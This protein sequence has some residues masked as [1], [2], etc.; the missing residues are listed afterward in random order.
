MVKD[1][2]RKW[3]DFKTMLNNLQLVFAEAG[4]AQILDG[5]GSRKATNWTHLWLQLLHKVGHGRSGDVCV[6]RMK[7]ITIVNVFLCS[8]QRARWDI[9][10][11][12]SR[13]SA[14]KTHTNKPTFWPFLYVSI[15]SELTQVIP[16]NSA[17]VWLCYT[18][19]KHVREYQHQVTA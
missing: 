2:V 16:T 6:Q 14:E 8:T 15:S 10:H 1:Y 19:S 17:T 13:Q 3:K 12:A 18:D 9:R 7:W 4:R 11:I 5:L